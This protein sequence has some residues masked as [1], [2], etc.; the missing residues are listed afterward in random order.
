LINQL[1]RCFSHRPRITV[2]RVAD[3][4]SGKLSQILPGLDVQLQ[5]PCERIDY[6]GGRI[7][8]AAPLKSQTIL[9]ADAGE[10]CQLLAKQPRSA[11][12]PAGNQ[13]DILWTDLVPPHTQEITQRVGSH[14]HR[15][16]LR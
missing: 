14:R 5:G 11:A 2:I 10:H 3:G 16:I 12:L 8:G 7:L 9:G 1:V 15:S 6:L 13:P 4:R